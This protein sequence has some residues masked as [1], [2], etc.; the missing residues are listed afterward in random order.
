MS[1]RLGDPLTDAAAIALTVD[2][3][4]PRFRRFQVSITGALSGNLAAL[5]KAAAAGGHVIPRI[6]NVDG[7]LRRVPMFIR[8]KDDYAAAD[9]PMLPSVASFRTTAV[10]ILASSVELEAIEAISIRGGAVKIN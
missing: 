4:D 9:V 10:R 6:D 8:Y 2:S 5:Q 1:L 3:Y 7:V